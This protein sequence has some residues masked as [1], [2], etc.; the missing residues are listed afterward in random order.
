MDKDARHRELEELA[1]AG[2][3]RAQAVAW[4]RAKETGTPFVVWRDG[5]VVDLNANSAPY[6][7]EIAELE[8]PRLHEEPED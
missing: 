3:R 4:K 5:K 2:L 7:V 1:T 6:E 8:S